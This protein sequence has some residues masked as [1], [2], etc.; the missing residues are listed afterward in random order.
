MTLTL[1]PLATLAVILSLAVRADARRIA[2]L[3]RAQEAR[4]D[5]RRL[6]RLRA[7]QEAR[8]SAQDRLAARW[9]NEGPAGPFPTARRVR[10][11]RFSEN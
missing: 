7:V 1:L 3:R 11:D 9:V 8:A 5:A 10:L 4:A 2:H 6:A